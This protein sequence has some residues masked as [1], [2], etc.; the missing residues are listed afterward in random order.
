MRC[1][2]VGVLAMAFSVAGTACATGESSEKQKED[3]GP[4]YL[5]AEK[6]EEPEPKPEVVP[7]PVA[8]PAPGQAR[9]APP[10]EEIEEGEKKQ[11]REDAAGKEPHE[12]I[13]EAN[14]E[15]AQKPLPEGYYNAIQKYDYAR[16][17]LYQVYAA[18]K[19]V[20]ALQFGAGEKIKSV[21]LGDTTRWI[22][23]RT[24]MGSGEGL[25]EVVL[26]KPVRAFLDTNMTVTTTK[27]VYQ[28]EL[29]SYEDSYMAAVSW[30]YPGSMVK[31][32]K[33]R[34][35]MK[36]SGGEAKKADS[37]ETEEAASVRRDVESLNFKYSFVL[38]DKNDR[39]RWMP[40]RVFDD[41]KQT[42]IQFP[43]G[44]TEKEAPALFV[45][46]ETGEPKVVNYRVKGNTYIVD[47]VFEAAE[48]RLGEEDPVTVGIERKEEG[49]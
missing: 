4:V 42:F 33:K 16:G 34:G 27:R 13:D 3:K 17:V 48:L 41:G 6:E 5:E 45:L 22:I 11:A 44:L 36:A 30:R 26:V 24:E 43:P 25:R 49:S 31:E 15:A 10:A 21:A 7:Y 12:I 19:R 29:H 47:Q 35:K 14:K 32:Y 23:G 9:P 8:Q 2:I 37:G 20:T 40:R 18:E 38:E 46:S 1:W 39:P 28:L